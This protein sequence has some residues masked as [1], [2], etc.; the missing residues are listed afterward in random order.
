MTWPRL[1]LGLG[2]FRAMRFRGVRSASG[3]ALGLPDVGRGPRPACVLRPRVRRAGR[4]M[5]AGLVRLLRRCRRRAA[6]L[7]GSLLHRGC[8]RRGRCRCRRRAGP[9]PAVGAW[10]RGAPCLRVTTA[11]ALAGP[12]RWR[13]AGPRRA[14]VTRPC[15]R[16]PRRLPADRRARRRVR[17]R[18]R[19][20][21]GRQA[22]SS[23][24]RVAPPT[25]RPAV[26]RGSRWAGQVRAWC[27]DPAPC[28]RRGGPQP[29]SRRRASRRAAPRRP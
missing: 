15:R 20:S 29:S 4:L 9:L 6:L 28:R 19:R 5:W 11:R 26:A 8:G 27:G 22:R 16:T 3:R 12:T 17:T 25:V 24:W 7:G 23:R 13:A 2:L 14:P 10:G 21:R 1:W 18:L